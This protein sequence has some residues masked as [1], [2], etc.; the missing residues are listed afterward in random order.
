MRERAHDPPPAEADR[1]DRLSVHRRGVEHAL[2][3][4]LRDDARIV[5]LVRGKRRAPG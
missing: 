4:A 5:E 3:F 2:A 1:T